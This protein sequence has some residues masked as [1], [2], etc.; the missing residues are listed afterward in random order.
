[1]GDEAVVP[2]EEQGDVAVFLQDGKLV[3][4]HHHE[5]AYFTVTEALDLIDALTAKIGEALMKHR[6]DSTKEGRTK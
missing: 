6:I 1:M 5:A 2:T 4:N 3:I